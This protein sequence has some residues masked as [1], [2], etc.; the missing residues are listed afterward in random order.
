M[1]EE[2]NPTLEG[3]AYVA[4]DS[5]LIVM[6]QGERSGPRTRTAI[7]TELFDSFDSRTSSSGSA[8]KATMCVPA[9]PEVQVAD[10]SA[11]PLAAIGPSVERE[12]SAPST[13][14]DRKSTR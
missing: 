2:T 3:S 14:K 6:F 11:D 10:A 5:P 9:G 12:I 7:S 13:V 4:F 1:G 8:T